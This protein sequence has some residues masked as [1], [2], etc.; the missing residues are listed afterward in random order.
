MFASL[1]HQKS[2]HNQN[3]QLSY[4]NTPVATENSPWT[5]TTGRR[6]LRRAPDVDDT[7][8]DEAQELEGVDEHE[9][10][11]WMH[12]EGEDGDVPLE[13]HISDRELVLFV[14]D[15][16][17]Y[18]DTLPVY[19]ITHAIR[20]LIVSRC[21][22]TLTW[23]QLRSPQ[24]SQFMVR[25]IQQKVMASRSPATLYAL[26][27]NCLQFE[28]EV[29]LYP[30]NSGASQTRAMVSELLAIKLLRE[31]TTRELIDALSYEFYPL[32]GQDPSSWTAGAQGKRPIGTAR[33]SCLEV[34]IRAQAKRFLAH[35][36]VVQQLEAIWAGTIVFHS[37]ADH[38]H[39]PMN[40]STNNLNYGTSG[41]HPGNQPHSP[42]DPRFRRSV[43]LYNPR[44]ASLFKLSRLR[45]PRYRQFLSTLSFAILLGLFLAV[46]NERSRKITSL[47]VVFWFWSA[48][49][50]LDEIVGFNEQGFSLYLMSFWNLFDV[51]I[52]I[53][54][55]C[56]YCLRIYG[57][58]LTYPRN[59]Q[60]AD[61]AYDMLA[62]N[63]VLLF[64]RLFS[65]LDHYRYFSQL[66]IA[67]RIMAADLIAVIVLIVIACSGFFI[68]FLSF[69]NDDS[70]KAVAYGLFQMVM[71]FTPTAWGMWDEYNWLG[72]TI[73]TVFLFICHFVVV[74][75]LITVLTNS[76]MRIVQNANE[77]HQFLFAVNTISMV[78]SD[79]LFSY[80]APANVI[81]WLVTPLRYTMPFRQFIK[82]N[83]TIIKITH[84]P[85][86]FTICLYE[87]TILSARVIE[88]MDLLEPLPRT[89][90]SGSKWRGRFRAFSSR[91]PRLVR[92]PSVATYQ[93]DQALDE[94]F[95]RPFDDGHEQLQERPGTIRKKTNSVI[96]DWMQDIGPNPA[97][98][99]PDSVVG[100]FETFTPRPRF[101]FRKALTGYGR[102][103]TETT[104]SVTSNPED[105]VNFFGSSVQLRQKELAAAKRSRQ[106]SP[107]TDIEGDDELTTD[108]EG[109]IDKSDKGSISNPDSSDHVRSTEKTTP[110]FYSSRPSTAK[111]LS[112]R[113]SP[114][115]RPNHDR[116]ASG[117]TILY[118]PVGSVDDDSGSPTTSPRLRRES[119]SDE[120]SNLRIA[121]S[122]DQGTMKRRSLKMSFARNASLGIHQMSAP[123]SIYL[124]DSHSRPR[125]PRSML[126]DLGS[127]L[128]D[129][130]AVAGGFAG[131]VPSIFH[132][133]LGFPA[134]DIHRDSPSQ[135][136][137]MLSKLVLARMNNIEEGF[138]EVIKEVKDLRLGGSSRGQSGADELRAATREKKKKRDLKKRRPAAE[139]DDDTD[140][141]ILANPTIPNT[142]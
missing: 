58:F 21:E 90:S 48:G 30:G 55:F 25:P 64:P 127:D 43:T 97:P 132:N 28:K 3:D 5:R 121:S 39:R 41:N 29:H 74:T 62:A 108:D 139:V 117:V 14:T 118:N 113:N 135:T 92:E 129:N 91:P 102:D 98:D 112:R 4:N 140:A 54:L 59:Q 86:L 131:H 22:T 52:L 79:A 18:P 19:D 109:S 53:L 119:S 27:A 94:V 26:M 51:G 50:M 96:K 24:V 84:L 70:P 130:K 10:E 137:D 60:M 120:E 9:D 34:A 72:R 68:A 46:L 141:K 8:E 16:I 116:S 12:E 36:V 107:H 63:A 136:Q 104:R 81:A 93:K 76:F 105:R 65:V 42:G 126:F 23:D 44:E 128:G 40:P 61:Q 31:Y 134:S 35:P 78:K 15:H 7:S 82:L 37:A 77:E 11:D 67:F 122:A 69:G 80:V 47:E 85:I 95:R 45:V 49:F 103:F 138:R 111:I 87:K 17:S 100:R 57:T 2:R 56:Y 99:E 6:V 125:R 124:S 75:I 114:S 133:R 83:R 110:K 73:L 89:D 115:R 20:P 1:F 88:T 123:Q 71:G 33:I 38:L 142:P 13:Y 32:Q 66:L 101:P 106:P